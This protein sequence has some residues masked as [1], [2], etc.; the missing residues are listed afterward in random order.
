MKYSPGD[1]VHNMEPCYIRFSPQ[2]GGEVNRYE[3]NTLFTIID[4]NPDWKY[5]VKVLCPDGNVGFL[6]LS[7]IAGSGW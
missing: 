2:L 5:F 4:V 3:S 7:H 6:H 1:P